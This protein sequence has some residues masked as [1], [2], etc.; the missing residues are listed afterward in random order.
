MLIVDDADKANVLN[1]FVRD[2][3]II[4]DNGVEIPQFDNY[5][6][7]SELSSLHLTP[8]EIDSF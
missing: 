7:L 6:V 3:T 4:N 2:Q 8:V 5:N 1:D